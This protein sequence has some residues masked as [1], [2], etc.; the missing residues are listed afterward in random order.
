MKTIHWFRGWV[1]FR[2][3]LHWLVL[4]VALWMLPGTAWAANVTVDCNMGQSINAA[5]GAL[6]LLGPH[7]IT[8][9][10]TCH[11][12]VDII[13]RQQVTIQAPGGQMA[14]IEPTGPGTV[15]VFVSQSRDVVLRQLVFHSPDVDGAGAFIQDHSQVRIIGCVIENNPGGGVFV[16]NE[17]FLRIRGTTIQN[18]GFFGAL[19]QSHSEGVFQGGNTIANNGDIGVQVFD[20]SRGN[21][22]GGTTITGHAFSGIIVATGSL[23]RG[24]PTIQNNGCT[25]DP[26]CSGLIAIRNSTIRFTGG[27]I[28]NNQGPG[29]RAEQLINV[30][31]NNVTFS[32]N[33]GVGVQLLRMSVGD[34]LFANTFSGNGAGSISC[35]TTSLAVGDM[36]GVT[37]IN[38]AR[39]ERQLG[40]PRPGRILPPKE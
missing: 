40:P 19:V 25:G 24:A 14:T 35:D 28:S 18:N 20:V 8:V 3:G 13:A 37:D 34:F 30:G 6:D 2:T 21:F 11:E 4:G 27:T 36:T 23:V 17:S 39:V 15:A 26:Q 16:T 9:T 31:L 33:T 38:C 10:G 7:T 5:L 12:E 1:S 22:S 29:I 32:N